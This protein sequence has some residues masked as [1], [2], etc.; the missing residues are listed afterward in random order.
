MSISTIIIIFLSISVITFLMYI[1]YLHS[2]YN[3]LIT[4]YKKSVHEQE[5]MEAR[6]KELTDKINELHENISDLKVENSKLADEK[7]ELTKLNEKYKKEIE[8]LKE[9]VKKLQAEI[10]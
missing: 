8:Q 3:K 7:D 5:R 6:F 9:R 1:I 4:L 10:Y 2:E